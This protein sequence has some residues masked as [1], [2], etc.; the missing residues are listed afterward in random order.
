MESM[1]TIYDIAKETGLSPST[2]S[3]RLNNYKGV[4]ESSKIK[5]D[6]AILKLK[7]VPNLSAR[8]I[9]TKKSYMIGVLFKESSDIGLLHPHFSEILECF[10]HE[11]ESKGYDT[12]FLS[13]RVGN[14]TFTYLE[15]CKYRGLDGV[16]LAVSADENFLREQILE[17]SKSELPKVS[18]EDIYDSVTS[19]LSENINGTKEALE[20]LYFL[21]HRNI[22]FVRVLGNS[23]ASKEREIGYREF[24]EENNLEFIEENIINVSSYSYQAGFE[25]ID[26]LLKKGIKNIPTA[27]CC[28]Y[29]EI[30][31]GIID[32]FKNYNILVPDDISIIGFDDVP[33][34]KFREI[35]TITQ[36]R[37]EIGI[38][39]AKKLINII[40]N[41]NID[42]DNILIPTK[43]TIRNTCKR[44]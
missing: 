4:S 10:R 31:L 20:Y 23:V 1:V 40:E 43:L 26:V 17:L 35:T 36:N 14:D 34:A 28:V 44:I 24:L 27:I 8:M 30:C 9:T 6:E 16:M 18:I 32:S 21:G 42:T 3:K 38:A 39:A 29:D 37:K 7:Y 33:L 41:Q 22:V 2:V 13:N 11:L 5:I 25:V 15:H 12:V 19:V